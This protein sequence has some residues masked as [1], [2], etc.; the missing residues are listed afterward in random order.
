MPRVGALVVAVTAIACRPVDSSRGADS[1]PVPA[2]PAP[3][4]DTQA[5]VHVAT[6][7]KAYPV[8]EGERDPGFAAFRDSLLRIIARRDTSA[9]LAIVAPDVKVSFGGDDGLRGFREHWRLDDPDTELWATLDDVLRHGGRH[10]AGMF[11]A[12][13]TFHALPDSLDAFEHLVVR[14]SGVVVRE[15]PDAAS[16][17]LA[18]LS[19]DIVRAGPYGGKSPWRAIA[20]GDGRVGYVESSRIRSPVDYRAG[21]ARREGRWRLVFF[22]AGD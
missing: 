13:W 2:V 5:A 18:V 10:S 21:F 16:A 17:A 12:P 15:R 11:V 8:D 6:Y 14:D 22:V 7:G 4:P 19:F 1:L 20:L 3:P 9:L